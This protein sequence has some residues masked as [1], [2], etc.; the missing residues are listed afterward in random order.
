MESEIWLKDVA[1]FLAAAGIVAPLF[2]AFKQSAVLAFLLAGVLLGPFGLGR[3][4]SDFSWLHFITISDPHAV[5]PMGEAGILFLLFML[6]L[7]MSFGRLWALRKDVFGLGASQVLLSA[8]LIGTVCYFF[9][10]PPAAASVIGL[11]LALSSTAIVMQIL[12]ETHSVA[13]PMG[14]T[15]FSVLLFQDLMVAPILILIGFLGISGGNVVPAL[16]QAIIGGAF[17]IGII[18]LVGRFA[19]RPAF[20]LAASSGGR[21]MMLALTFLAVLG[22]SAATAYAGLSLALGAFLAGLLLGETEFKTQIEIDLEPFKGLLIG[23]F[24]MT[25]GMGI[26]P[27]E[28]AADWPIILGGTIALVIIKALLVYGG[29]RIF[30]KPRYISIQ[31]ATL[32]GPAG[33]FAFIVLGAAT[34][35]A[36]VDIE[37]AALITAMAGLSM[38][39]SPFLARAGNAMSRRLMPLDMNMGRNSHN[40]GLDGHVVIAGYGRVGR[41]LA[42]LIRGENAEIV[43]IDS[44]PRR[45]K[46]CRKDGIESL[47]GDAGRFDMLK[48]AGIDRASQFIVT[49]DDPDKAERVVTTIRA[50]RKDAPITAR[51]VDRE[52]ADA[53]VSAG[54]SH[55]IHEAAEAALQLAYQALL[56]F[57]M[58]SDSARARIAHAREEI[59]GDPEKESPGE[60]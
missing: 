42:N 41:I 57:G 45:I 38:I 11:G 22:A 47:F 25:V 13:T 29:A 28:F 34:A 24:F 36:V 10:V 27:L 4:V 19:V 5:E 46:Q 60:V 8:A 52:H 26:D 56:D 15:T 50:H 58:T 54:A 59:Y 32:L 49:V 21:E 35:A 9:G 48:K 18:G 43:A 31:I 23:L 51:A 40:D 20:Q 14:R 16:V 17:A 3:L 30:G 6:G 37:T 1:V 53:L 33:E 44:N 2:R 12:F 39:I 7:E 55:V